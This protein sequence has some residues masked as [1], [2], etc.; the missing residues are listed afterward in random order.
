MDIL[1]YVVSEGLVMIPVLN[2]LGWTVKNS[3]VMD[4]KYI[5][6]L[7]IVV[8]LL[9]TPWLLGGFNAT[10][11][12]QALLIPGGAVLAHQSVKQAKKE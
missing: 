2:F 4:S 7:L 5:P 10:N 8:S 9:L 6:Y 12:I 11:V 3:E 1:E